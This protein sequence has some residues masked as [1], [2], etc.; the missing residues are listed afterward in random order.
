MPQRRKSNFKPGPLR[1]TFIREWRDYRGY[2]QEQLGDMIGVSHATIGR[3]E[4]GK[5]PYDQQ[6]LELLADALTTDPASLLVRNP[7]APDAIWTLWDLAKPGEREQIVDLAR[8]VV[9]RTGTG[10]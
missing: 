3:V 8:V 6:L 1:R 9:R 10:G 7:K 4:N 5:K 2:T